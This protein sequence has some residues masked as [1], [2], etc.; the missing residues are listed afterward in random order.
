MRWD[1]VFASAMLA[2]A[3]VH[4]GASAVKLPALSRA[5]PQLDFGSAGGFGMPTDRN[6]DSDVLLNRPTEP[7]SVSEKSVLPSV[8]VGPFHASLHGVGL[9]GSISGPGENDPRSTW[10]SSAGTGHRG[11]KLMLTL[12]TH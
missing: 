6:D 4:A 8:N 12:P 3:P 11:A 10:I 7:P 5:V 1:L 2:A 9:G